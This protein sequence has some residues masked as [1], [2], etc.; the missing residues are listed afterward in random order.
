MYAKSTLPYHRSLTM[1]KQRLS[2]EQSPRCASPVASRRTVT[3]VTL[4]IGLLAGG[5]SMISRPDSGC[6][7][8]TDCK[9]D[10]VCE[11]RRC[12][13]ARE[14]ST[15]DDADSA[16]EIASPPSATPPT[17]MRTARFYRGGAGHAGALEVEGPAAQP[18]M[19]WEV[20][21]GAVVYASPRL[22]TDAEG[23]T[24]AYLGTHA[25][26]LYGIVVDG[27]EAGTVTLELEL[28]AR[29]WST[30][31]V[32]G[33]MLYVGTDRDELVAV[34]LRGKVVAWRT[35]LGGCEKTTAP[36]P[37]GSRCDADGGPTVGPDGDLYVGA[38]GVY[39]LRRDGSIVWHWP[40]TLAE[41]ERPPHVASTP[42]VTPDGRVMFGAQ[43][44]FVHALDPDGQERWR[45]KVVADVDGSGWIGADGE[46]IVGA[47]DGR[48]YALRRDG[49][50]RWSFV[51]QKDIRSGVGGDAGERVYVTSH[52][53]NLYA[54]EGSGAVAWV[55]QTGA[56]IQSTPV[57]D[58]G[59]NVYVGGQDNALYA[60]TADGTLRWS[61]EFPGDVD[62]SVAISPRGTLVVG[63]DDGHLRAFG[64]GPTN[65]PASPKS[66]TTETARDQ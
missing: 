34:D 19:R 15:T 36:G 44:G 4:F 39:R 51:A 16:S 31:W 20:D 11:D 12:V 9:Q 52:D 62:S 56:P 48:V 57:V 49:S 25:G 22:A 50:L 46:F 55:F 63:C 38:D 45:Y 47:D 59:G 8:D 61:L 17:A 21:L 27:P 58:A 30:P 33:E 24:V 13:S 35:R 66:S 2:V 54:L 23:V 7:K 14:E 32:D 10:R 1:S 53:G 60:L 42:V 3:V 28:G 29:I 6:S 43:D 37:E 41:G 18:A 5:C 26:K 40:S 64:A 65:A